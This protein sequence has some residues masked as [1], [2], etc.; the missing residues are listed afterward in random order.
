M[1]KN[2]R[3][4]ADILSNKEVLRGDEMI[5][6]VNGLKYREYVL[7]EGQLKIDVDE[8]RVELFEID[9]REVLGQAKAY[10][11]T[12]EEVQ[13]IQDKYFESLE[14]EGVL[15][16]DEIYELYKRGLDIEQLTIQEARYQSVSSRMRSNREIDFEDISEENEIHPEKTT[17]QK[18]ELIK[19]QNDAMYLYCLTSKEAVTINS[20][21]EANFKGD[22]K[23][24]IQQYTQQEVDHVLKMNGWTQTSGNS[25]ATRLL[26]MYDMGVSEQSVTKLQNLR[27]VVSSLDALEGG[28]LSGEEI[29]M[30]EDRM[31]YK[32]EYIDRITDDL[33]MVTDEHIEKLI[34]EN[35]EIHIT[36]L[37]ESIHKKV[38]EVLKEGNAEHFEQREELTHD[39]VLNEVNGIGQIEE[40]K[41]QIHQIRTKLTVEA[42]QKISRQM[43]LESSRLSEVASVLQ[44]MEEEEAIKAL[45]GVGLPITSENVGVVN[46]VISVTQEMNHYFMETVQIEM[47]TEGGLLLSEIQN[48]LD[49]YRMNETPVEKRFGE[50]ITKV[51]DQ[52]QDLLE[53]QNIE[54]SDLTI[55]ATKALIV[56]GVEVNP[57]NIQRLQE[58]IIK[59]NTFLEEITPMQVAACIK[60][61]MNPYESSVDEL[62]LWMAD[63]KIE[64]LKNSVAETIVA[65]ERDGTINEEQKEGMIGLYRI[66]RGVS[67]QKEEVVG[68][69]DKNKLSLTLE[70]LQRAVYYSENKKHM[71]IKVDDTYGVLK[72][73]AYDKRTAKELIE[74]GV[75]QSERVLEE[76]KVLENMELPIKEEG[77]HGLAKISTWLYPYIKEQ[78][79]RNLGQFEG[80]K[81]LPDSFLEKLENIKGMNS[82]LI[83]YMTQQKIPL[84]LSN[85]Y[86]MDRLTK[87]PD[88]YSKLLEH[89]NLLQEDIPVDLRELERGLDR[90]EKEMKE[91]K[92]EATLTG[93]LKEYRV[94]KE[95]E[96][97]VRFQ[98]ERIEKEGLYQIPFMIEGERKLI[99]L[100]FYKEE[101][102]TSNDSETHLKAVLTYET[103][104]LGKI[105][106]YIE[107][108]GD[109]IGYK[110]EAETVDGTKM[111]GGEEKAL[112]EKLKAI[113]YDVQYSKFVDGVI[114]DKLQDVN[115]LKYEESIF[116]TMI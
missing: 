113:G 91:Q 111:L 55:E 109:V 57:N 65:M 49:T 84:T 35:K 28:G 56:N 71:E 74:E 39:E 54:V 4:Y 73:L 98:K 19:K 94:Y 101:N 115:R 79:K 112:C 69:L 72:S 77:S 82:E 76:I 100:Y 67:R 34:E 1:L 47:A 27:S 97:V 96:E 99:N 108:K 86:W 87:E 26:M 63:R 23:K 81:T 11:Y 12:H 31:Q 78:F 20:L 106:A 103:K 104:H 41:K 85:L 8:P 5:E 3:L 21:Y 95:I 116:E 64:G 25:W 6:G 107:L 44:Q 16:E 10:T 75:Q 102:N 13:S 43:P 38:K 40:I 17:N 58:I 33:G 53:S 66:L 48:A 70:N 68:Y 9:E 89:K 51:E 52:I 110:V 24:G 88:M 18:I 60:E 93:E 46:Q 61:G 7:L 90:L 2:V 114:N 59:L 45:K 50:N 15:Q 14:K 83:E 30:K 80:I 22:F 32:P 92:E 36:E 42:A 62:L 37:R 29:F 105:K